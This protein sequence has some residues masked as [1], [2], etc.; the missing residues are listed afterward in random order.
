MQ[1]GGAI[2]LQPLADGALLYGD[3]FERAEGLKMRGGDRRDHCN[4]R[5]GHTRKG[6]DLAGVIH[7]DLEDGE[8]CL[9]RHA[10]K[11]QRHTPVIVIGGLR[12]VGAALPCADGAEHFF[13]G[14]FA[15]R[16]SHGDD[17]CLCAGAG[18]ATEIF[19]RGQDIGHDEQRRICWHVI[20]AV[21]HKGGGG[22]FLQGL[23]DEFM[24]IARGFQRDEEIT[25]GDGAG[26]DRD[27]GCREWL[28]DLT[29]C[30]GGGIGGCP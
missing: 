18:R 9:R 30:G 22:P 13:R 29:A 21:G 16:A 25:L 26:V 12:R 4:M 11:R 20:G 23:G 2:W 7:A 8:L 14:S 10:G 28:G 27:A 24:A 19:Q 3:S 17:F 15:D 1:D 5:A 6:R